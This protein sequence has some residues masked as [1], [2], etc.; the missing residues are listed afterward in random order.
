MMR[1]KMNWLSVFGLLWTVCLSA[2]TM[3]T[4]YLLL[5]QSS[6]DQESKTRLNEY[7]NEV[8]ATFPR[9]RT[10]IEKVLENDELKKALRLVYD[11][12][13]A[14]KLIELLD[15]GVENPVEISRNELLKQQSIK[16]F[17]DEIKCRIDLSEADKVLLQKWKAIHD[18]YQEQVQ[19]QLAND[20]RY[21]KSLSSLL[22]KPKYSELVKVS[23]NGSIK[24]NGYAMQSI[25][26]AYAELYITLVYLAFPEYQVF[27]FIDQNLFIEN[28]PQAIVKHEDWEFKKIEKLGKD[29]FEKLLSNNDNVIEIKLKSQ[30][31][32]TKKLE[33]EQLNFI[34]NFVTKVKQQLA[35]EDANVDKGL[36]E[37]LENITKAVRRSMSVEVPEGV[38]GEDMQ[39]RQLRDAFEKEQALKVKAQFDHIQKKI[40][41]TAQEKALYE[42]YK[43]LVGLDNEL[44]KELQ[45]LDKER[46][47]AYLAI[48]NNPKFQNLENAR[49]DLYTILMAQPLLAAVPPAENDVGDNESYLRFVN[50]FYTFTDAVLGKLGGEIDT[51]KCK[52]VTDS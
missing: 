45:K 16:I 15:K 8:D 29:F 42:R 31:K 25:Q 4:N 32:E 34:N 36:A 13:R 23:P 21:Q 38:M 14:N 11:E 9:L 27:P 3:E 35:L 33:D 52:Q 26:R 39:I 7:L 43:S 22:T 18:L 12:I 50:L 10:K 48:D 41:L 5:N 51:P 44:Q 19:E 40:S 30:K 24:Y 46:H 20:N 1:R 47:E 37:F 28:K 17:F 49:L 6:L 2:G